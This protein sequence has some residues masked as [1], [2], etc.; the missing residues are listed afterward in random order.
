MSI[1]YINTGSG[2]NAGDGDSLRSAF[3]KVNNNFT[4]FAHFED[5]TIGYTGS[6]GVTGY[7][8]STGA[9]AAIGYT[10]SAG[11]LLTVTTTTSF[12]G[13]QGQIW[14]NQIDGRAYIRDQGVWFDLSPSVAPDPSTYL[15]R[16]TIDGTT[17][18]PVDSTSTVRMQSNS[19]TWIF[20]TDGRLTLPNGSTIGDSDAVFGVP[21]T[22]A[23]G[24]IFLG[25]QAECGNVNHFHIMKA[26]QQDIELF[27]GD[28]SN[29]VKLPSTGG[30]EISSSEIGAQHYWNFGTD[31]ILNFPNNNGQI[32]QLTSPY[33]GLE[34]RTGSGADWIGISY[35]EINDNNTSYFYFDKDGS[36]YTTANHRAHLQIKSPEQAYGASHLEWLFDADGNLTIPH[37]GKLGFDLLA[38]HNYGTIVLQSAGGTG[39]YAAIAGHWSYVMASDNEVRIQ[40]GI[41]GSPY[42]DWTFGADGKL[43]LPE[44]G[45]FT[46]PNYGF[47]FNKNSGKTGA[48]EMGTDVTFATENLSSDIVDG[49]IYMG[50]GYGEFRSIFNK[51]DQINSG[52]VYAGVEG[53]N[54]VQYGDVNFAGMVSQT[55][56]I[57]SMYSVGVNQSGQITIGFTQNGQTQQSNDWSVVVGSLNIDM[58]VN[59]LFADTNKTVISGK[60]GIELNTDRGTIHFGNHP[61]IGVASHFHIM[62]D[63]PEHVNLFFGDDYNYVKLPYYSTLTNVGVE[64]SANNNLWKFDT[65][66]TLTIPG[67]IQDANGSVI[68]IATTSTAPT[69][70]NGQLWFNTED[71]RGYIRYNNT[72]IDLNPPE[73]P[74]PSTYLDGLIIDGTTISAVDTTATVSIES[75]SNVWEFGTDGTLTFPAGYALPNTVGTAGQVLSVSTNSNVL[76]W[77]TAS[78]G[79]SFKYARVQ[80]GIT[81]HPVTSITGNSGDGL[82]LTSDR[83]AQ[84]MWVPNTSAVTLNDIDQ[85]APVYNWAYVDV[86]GFNV[87]NKHS[88]TTSTWTFGTDGILTLPL[89]S[90]LNSGGVGVAN[91]AEFGTSVTVSTSTVVNSEIY[92]GSGYGEF[93]SIYNKVG[94]IESGLTYAGVEGFNYAQ[95][96][97][98]NFSGMVSQ[99]PHIDSMYTISVSTTTGLISIGFTQ[100]GGTSVSK[101]W[102]TVLGTLNA[103]YTVNGIFADT[104][105]TVISGGDGVLSSIV[106]LT[107]SVNITTIDSIITGTSTWIFGSDGALTFPDTSTQTTAW[108]GGGSSSLS[109][110]DTASNNFNTGNFTNQYNLDIEYTAFTGDYGVN[111]DITYQKPLDSTKGVTVGA[112]E[113]PLI[114]STGTVILKTDIGSSTSTWTFGIDGTLTFPNGANIAI[115]AGT[116]RTGAIAI[117]SSTELLIGTNTTTTNNLWTFGID[118]STVFPDNT[119]KGYCFTATNTVFNYIPT[120]AAFM[121]TDSPILGLIST[122]GGSWYIKGPGLVGWKQITGVLDNGGGVWLV[123]IGP[124]GDGS[125]F[126][127]GGYQPNSPNLVYT[128]SQYLDLDLKAADKTWTFSENGSLTFPNATVQTTAYTGTVA[129]SNITGAPASVNKTSGSWILDTGANTVSITVAPGGNYQMWVNGTC[130]N[131]IVNWNATVNVSNTNVPAIGVQYGWYY[132]DGNA[133][134][135]TAIPDQIVGTAGVI[136]TATVNTTTSNVFNFGITNNSISTQTVYWGYTTL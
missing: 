111:F 5:V 69:R 44:G 92:M 78:G 35:G 128:I 59:G 121:Y 26:G 88:G 73:V 75:G 124:M 29:Y 105:Q 98:V 49:E 119:V 116:P 123:D 136:S 66:T 8:G 30:V 89:E 84:L 12:A 46:S 133:L 22:T 3:I 126:H 86:T 113:T 83:W 20:G 132:Y 38:D 131:G 80:E 129:Y 82:S 40:T 16:L 94:A 134:V 117:T 2:A 110:N 23:R 103:Y 18:T 36:D 118:G 101:D 71:G 52:L 13:V 87:E 65:D 34:F 42:Y 43:T 130:D 10:G 100:D 135:L 54:Y 95:Y 21:I 106:K 62:R 70:V 72:W 90:K 6:R 51:G 15:D 50:S 104:T 24:T 76:Y 108:L 33:T 107:D 125:E 25:N 56:N 85:G 37:G 28:D 31:G 14:F 102:I 74:P 81:S 91:S 57:D 115:P 97:D 7:T 9:Y 53:F 55:P 63:D 112:I 47:S 99:T 68:R 67:D 48:P 41:E 27:L 1:Q 79:A 17:I 77:T 64:I 58:T 45:A 60:H 114:M 122:I 4:K 96:G 19:N 93:R 127:S 109:T 39:T 61:E 32:G 11:L 120:R